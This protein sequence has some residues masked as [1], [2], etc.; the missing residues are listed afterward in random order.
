MTE[1]TAQTV[2]R[3][4]QNTIRTAAIGAY[5]ELSEKLAATQGRTLTGKER[6]NLSDARA[7][8]ID[9]IRAYAEVAAIPFVEAGIHVIDGLFDGVDSAAEEF[10]AEAEPELRGAIA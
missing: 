4:T 8:V 7:L 9:L 10:L 3:K 5:Q 1:I 6:H 2:S